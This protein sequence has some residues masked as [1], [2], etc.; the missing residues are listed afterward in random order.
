MPR[1]E[2]YIVG[3]SSKLPSPIRWGS[4]YQSRAQ[5][6]NGAVNMSPNPEEGLVWGVEEVMV[7]EESR[8]CTWDLPPKHSR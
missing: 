7:I 3:K 1:S 2:F 4:P 6:I 8:G 5:A